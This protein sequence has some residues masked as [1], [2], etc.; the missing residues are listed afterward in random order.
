MSSFETIKRH[1][2][3]LLIYFF[4]LKKSAAEVPDLGY[5]NKKIFS[6]SKAEI[7]SNNGPML[8]Q[9]L[10]LPLKTW[11]SGENQIFGAATGRC[12]AEL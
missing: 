12:C 7:R 10:A 11:L 4:N 5:S 6:Q 9:N 3:E 8:G 1:L 2:R